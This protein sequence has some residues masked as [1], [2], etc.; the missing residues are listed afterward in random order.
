MRAE[1]AKDATEVLSRLNPK[2]GYIP[3][4]S[5]FNFTK[6]D[7]IY[8]RLL[9]YF[10]LENPYKQKKLSKIVNREI[11][12]FFGEVRFDLVI[13]CSCHDHITHLMCR[14]LGRK[15]LESNYPIRK[16]LEEADILESRSHNLSQG[17]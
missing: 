13:N 16:I 7:Y 11:H 8:L 6:S 17:K 1:R 9:H 12:K 15:T 10:T 4:S 2:I 14:R 5:D 3:L